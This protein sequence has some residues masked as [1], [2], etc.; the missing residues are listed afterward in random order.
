MRK[1]I[2]PFLFCFLIFP[3]LLQAQQSFFIEGKVSDK[4]SK[5]PL[6]AY[7]LEEEGGAGCTADGSG[8]FKL[9]LKR[10]K[11]PQTL[12]LSVWLIGYKKKD[13]E[14]KIGEYLT[15][16]LELEPIQA[17]E[18]VVTADSIVSDGKSQKTVTMNRMDIYTTPGAAAD[19]LYASHILP[20]VNSL[21]D[22]SSM[23]I[24]G[25]APDEVG[26]FFDGIE[27]EHPFLSE[28]LHESYFS[29]FDNQVIQ[30]FSVSTSGFHP[31][32]GDSLSGIM[33]IS[34]KD[35]IAKGE[36]G[37][38]LS[39]LGLNSYAGLPLKGIGSF[40]G[41]YNL[42]YSDLMTWMNNRK[43]REFQTENAF[44]KF[45]LQ[46]NKSNSIRI[47]G[48]YDGYHF[49]QTDEFSAD[50]KN[51]IAAVSWT[52]TLAKN[53]VT[54][55][56]LSRVGYDVSL[57]IQD[58]L[59]IKTK[60]DAWQGRLETAVDFGRHFLEFGADLQKRST[61]V[62]ILENESQAYQVQ[63]TKRGFYFN[64]KFRISDHLFANLGARLFSLD[65]LNNKWHIAPRTSL[66]Y[67]LTRD[68]VL[69]FSL[70][71]YQQF[72]DY[73]TLKN[74]PSLRPK[75]AVHCALSYD[76]IKEETELRATLYDKEYR[77]LFLNKEEEIVSN[78]GYGYARGAEFFLK[79]KKKR[80]DAI[81][82]YNF[83]H[84]KRK[85]NDALV[86]SN[87]PYEIAHSLTAIFKWKFKNSS[88][89]IR[90]SYASGRPFTPLLGREWD[91]ESQSYLPLWGAPFSEHYP[92]YQRLDISG[93]KSLNILKRITVLYFGITNFL[94]NKN[95]L[96]YEYSDDYSSRMDQHSIFARTLFVGLYL[97]FF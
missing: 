81:L 62:N 74:N 79:K 39:V 71:V 22:A 65:L 52:S 17:N 42:G 36:G 63:G 57:N 64:D 83:L 94:N 16:E 54:K 47:Y 84:S 21:P 13:I 66:A 96:S 43:G 30:N 18:I 27:V 10:Q 5:D 19:P 59:Q 33:D 69:R 53:L 11:I 48:L 2:I 20:G 85:E 72:G 35:T 14:A 97:P 46:L 23:L 61:E 76:R 1:I 44:G 29:I 25:G 51:K 28:S 15:V 77:N 73:F 40:V 41:S 87:S 90:Y 86:L 9:T 38:G 80:Y 55:L 50:S 68:D 88:L 6:P 92:S 93:S 8:Y 95:I 34:V 31:Q 45:H 37:L 26:Y 91:S 32:Y 56:H 12:K 78:E 67:L 49:T 82:V 58:S 4:E 3:Y 60:D 7:V 70:G 75:L 89:G 24:R